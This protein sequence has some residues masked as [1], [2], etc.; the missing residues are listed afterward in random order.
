MLCLETDQPHAGGNGKDAEGDQSGG[1][2]G[3]DVRRK[4]PVR[5]HPSRQ[6]RDARKGRE[7]EQTRRRR[8]ESRQR[9]SRRLP[10]EEQ[11]ERTRKGAGLPF[12]GGREEKG[13]SGRG[14]HSGEVCPGRGRSRKIERPNREHDAPS[15]REDAERNA[16]DPFA[17]G[18]GPF[19]REQRDEDAQREKEPRRDERGEAAGG[20]RHGVLWRTGG[21]GLISRRCRRFPKTRRGAEFPVRASGFC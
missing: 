10:G 16:R 3:P 19:A 18:G 21:R 15:G 11:D 6:E 20:L 1:Q 14:Q 2:D 8:D 17:A 5:E 4:P 12:G 7:K 13:A 9:K